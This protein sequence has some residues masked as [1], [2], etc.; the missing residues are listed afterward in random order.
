MPPNPNK[1]SDQARPIGRVGGV[2]VSISGSHDGLGVWLLI[3][4]E[5]PDAGTH[6]ARL[7]YPLVNQHIDLVLFPDAVWR[8]CL[9][10]TTRV[11]ETLIELID[12]A[13]EVRR[14]AGVVQLT[15]TG[16]DDDTF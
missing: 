6:L 11:D 4:H 15:L 8:W 10:Y 2:E 14:A 16:F 1:L 9:P 13:A 3:D 5:P 7:L 12:V